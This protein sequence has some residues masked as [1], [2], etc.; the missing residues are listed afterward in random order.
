[1]NA[2][3]LPDASLSKDLDFNLEVVLWQFEMLGRRYIITPGS[4]NRCQAD[5]LAVADVHSPG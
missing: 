3:C 2:V 5:E 1:M 4:N